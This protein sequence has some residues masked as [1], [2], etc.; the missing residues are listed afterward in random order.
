[1]KITK[2]STY[3]D[4]LDWINE[5]MVL[6]SLVRYGIAFN[7]SITKTKSKGNKD[8][9]VECIYCVNPVV[10]RQFNMIKMLTE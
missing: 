3:I 7:T 10:I 1:M 9:L 4:A 6:F 2:S 5:T 8:P